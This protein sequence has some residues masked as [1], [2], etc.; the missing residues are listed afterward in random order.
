MKVDYGVES[1]LLYQF[2]TNPVAEK[3]NQVV[4]ITDITNFT[5]LQGSPAVCYVYRITQYLP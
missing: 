5:A 1:V 2:C 4:V 3:V